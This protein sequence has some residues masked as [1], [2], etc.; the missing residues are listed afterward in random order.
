MLH[1]QRLF[2]K[3]EHFDQAVNTMISLLLN[4]FYKFAFYW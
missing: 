2:G 4:V 1:Q 3:K